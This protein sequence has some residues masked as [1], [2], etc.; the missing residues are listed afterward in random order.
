MAHQR[1]GTPTPILERRQQRLGV[2]KGLRQTSEFWLSLESNTAM[3]RPEMAREG[4]WAW[5]GVRV[6]GT[7]TREELPS[8]SGLCCQHPWP[9]Q[10]GTGTFIPRRPSCAR[11]GDSR[12][13]GKC[14][15]QSSAAG[16]DP[17][18]AE[19]LEA[20]SVTCLGSL[21][22][23]WVKDLKRTSPGWRVSAKPR[24]AVFV[25]DGKGRTDTQRS[26]GARGRDTQQARRGFA[27]E[28]PEGPMRT[29]CG[30]PKALPPK[31]WHSIT[32]APGHD[33]TSAGLEICS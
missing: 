11:S 8:V 27:A 33:H 1:R 12:A 21:Q 7:Q 32:A 13:M 3:G 23:Q 6:G 19:G 17:A 20:R 30:W 25:R 16:E 5:T 15:V 26:R 24:E 4:G 28:A 18:G 22:Q 14:D 29:H 10:E 31:W 9:Q 2:G